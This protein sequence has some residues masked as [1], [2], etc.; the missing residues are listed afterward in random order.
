MAAVVTFILLIAFPPVARGAEPVWKKQWTAATELITT[1]GL[2]PEGRALLE[3]ARAKSPGFEKRILPGDASFTE[4]QQLG[5]YSAATGKESFRESLRIYINRRHSHADAAVDLA[6]ELVHLTDRKP[7]DPY[8]AS[9]T[10]AG[11]VRA[12]IE[13]EGGELAAFRAECR[14]AWALEKAFPAFPA[15]RQCGA[16]RR[17]TEI[18]P[19]LARLAYYAVGKAEYAKLA[20][21]L[22]KELPELSPA[23]SV[24]SSGL[25]SR[26]YPVMLSQQF[27]SSRQAACAMNRHKLG[28]LAKPLPAGGRDRESASVREEVKK[29]K[30]FAQ[31]HCRGAS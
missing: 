9:F 24:L 13:G 4:R 15:H 6:H 22:R 20:P 7:V 27:S 25:A 2:V 3:A 30:A 28:Q 18:D 11:Y 26:P 23:D 12:G 17:G 31:S 5:A 14:V 19:E 16:F 1:L 21:T 29:L 10:A 8:A